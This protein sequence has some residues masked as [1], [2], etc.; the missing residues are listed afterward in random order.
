M[1]TYVAT[2]G[3]VFGL[4]T[5]AHVWR[6]AE[7]GRH[8]ASEPSFVLI[9]AASTLLCVWACRLLWPSSRPNF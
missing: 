5:A 8:L 9:T 6:V 7:E 3:V 2:T 4:L 1:K